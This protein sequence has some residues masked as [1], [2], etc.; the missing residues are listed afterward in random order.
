M[1][2]PKKRSHIVPKKLRYLRLARK[3]KCDDAVKLKKRKTAAKSC[4]KR[5]VSRRKHLHR[6]RAMC[7]M[8]R[9]HAKGNRA[10]RR[11]IKT[12]LLLLGPPGAQGPVGIAGQIGSQG[13]Q[14]L[15]GHAGPKGL[16]GPPGPQGP[17]G[18]VIIPTITINPTANR[19][20]N[21]PDTDLNLTGPVFIPSAQFVNDEGNAVVSFDIGVNSFSNLFVNGILQ[22]TNSYELLQDGL[23]FPP[24]D[25][26]IYA[27]TPIIIEMI[28]FEA[29]IVV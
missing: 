12:Q 15:Q 1:L 13:P 3:W 24:Q 22:P 18:T 9:G 16:Q 21:F 7:R 8:K 25:K 26:T 17:A 2:C 4:L 20:F 19:Y 6:K 27:G 14:G 11:Q 23:I 5:N 28:Q 10:R 29:K